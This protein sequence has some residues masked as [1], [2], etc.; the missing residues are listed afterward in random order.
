[1]EMEKQMFTE[2][3]F[4]GLSRTMGHRVDSDNQTLLNSI[5]PSPYSLQ[6]CL[7]ITLIRFFI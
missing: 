2:Q 5:T 4:A 1:M 6:T 3:M 7:V